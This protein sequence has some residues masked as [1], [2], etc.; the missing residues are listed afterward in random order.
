[1]IKKDEEKDGRGVPSAAKM[2]DKQAATAK[3]GNNVKLAL[4]KM[5]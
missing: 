3:L 2:W 1:M 5:Y 4:D